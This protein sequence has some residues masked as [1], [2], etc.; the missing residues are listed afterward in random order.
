MNPGKSLDKTREN[1]KSKF[2]ASEREDEIITCFEI[3]GDLA[4][5]CLQQREK[6]NSQPSD[7]P[8]VITSLIEMALSQVPLLHL[9]TRFVC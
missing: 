9:K 2:K 3:A 8:F 4:L 7:S 6:R 1:M 5:L